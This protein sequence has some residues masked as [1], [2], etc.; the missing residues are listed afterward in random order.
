[1]GILWTRGRRGFV[2]HHRGR[3]KVYKECRHVGATTT[4]SST[5]FIGPFH[6]RHLFIHWHQHE[7]RMHQS[8]VVH[9]VW[10]SLEMQLS[11]LSDCCLQGIKPCKCKGKGYQWVGNWVFR[12][13]S[14]KELRKEWDLLGR[15]LQKPFGEFKTVNSIL[16]TK[17][18][19]HRTEISTKDIVTAVCKLKERNLSVSSVIVCQMRRGPIWRE[20]FQKWSR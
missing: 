10:S 12:L 7:G 9:H 17:Y 4:H 13:G 5:S 16:L 18:C 1:M 6:Q 19:S 11:W 2:D 14:I 20:A 3:T 15:D 8:H